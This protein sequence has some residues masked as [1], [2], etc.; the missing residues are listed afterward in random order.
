MMLQILPREQVKQ[1]E[2][3]PAWIGSAVGKAVKVI[4]QLL[5]TLP[6]EIKYKIVFAQR[7]MDEVLASQRA[8]L[9]RRGQAQDGVSDAEMATFFSRH[10]CEVRE[11]LAAQE[12]MDVLY[13]DYAAILRDPLAE[14]RRIKTF[15][16]LP[17]D[18]WQ[19]AGV[20]DES[21]Y[22]QRKS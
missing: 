15:L 13:V 19:M 20:V 10:L 21:L 3:G 18:E 9:E 14:S 12:N 16:A 11:W 22:R 5:S 8:M 6:G 17:M 1:L 4:S 7:E 2:Q